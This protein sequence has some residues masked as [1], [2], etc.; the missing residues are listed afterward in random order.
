[1][2]QDIIETYNQ[3]AETLVEK[4]ESKGFEEIHTTPLSFIPHKPSHILD[5][6]AGSGRDAA[7]F[8]KQG[9]TVIAVE[10]SQSLRKH[11]EKLHPSPSI[12]WINDSLPYLHRIHSLGLQYNL[13]WLSAVWMHI[14]PNERPMALH[15]I[16]QLL[17]PA[18]SLMISLRY[19]EPPANRKMYPVSA[20]ELEKLGSRNNLK[21]VLSEYTDDILNRDGV[22][23]QTVIMECNNQ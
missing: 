8:A 18:G 9:H 11:A 4:Y 16:S 7:Y 17:N 1:M 13:I 10:P 12:Q 15:S 2:E 5:I 6:G 20:E 21:I 3:E 14:P 19:G 22:W 23:W